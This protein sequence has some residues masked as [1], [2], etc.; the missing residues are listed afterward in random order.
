MILLRCSK[1]VLP[2]LLLFFGACSGETKLANGKYRIVG[3]GCNVESRSELSETQKADYFE[4]NKDK[5]FIHIESQ[6]CLV[7]IN[8]KIKITNDTMTWFDWIYAK[9]ECPQTQPGVKSPTLT[10]R[11][12]HENKLL[13]LEDLVNPGSPCGVYQL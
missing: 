7:E 4:I 5:V 9:N 6:G 1:V 3:K 10:W 13:I 2:V 12:R 8:A 11:F